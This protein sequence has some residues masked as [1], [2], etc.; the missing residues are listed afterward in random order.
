MVGSV[1][2]LRADEHAAW[3]RDRAEGSA[4]LEGRKLFLKFQ[5][6]SCHRPD[7]DARAPVLEG[8]YGRRVAFRGGG[9]A[10]ADET[11][12]RE[13]ILLPAR[14]VVEGWEPIMPTFQ[15]QASEEDVL[16]LIAYIRSLGRGDLP[17]PNNASPPPVGAPTRL[18]QDG[19]KK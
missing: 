10:V 2:V 18:P 12:I 3:L 6:V 17:R 14:Q 9:T 5:C 4:A 1:V 7:A 16:L 13:S 19:G 8:L 15:G 11:Y